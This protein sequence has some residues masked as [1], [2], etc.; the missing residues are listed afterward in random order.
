[1]RLRP[2]LT[3]VLAAAALALTACSSTDTPAPTHTVTV[4]APTPDTT[5]APTPASDDMTQLVV[6][7]S[8]GQQSEDDKDAMCLGIGVYGSEWAAEQMQAGAGDDSVDWNR[9]AE[10][11]EQKCA[12]R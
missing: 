3:T 12:E 9:A 6:D 2:T 7:I 11:V 4:E 5:P 8:W 10:L 1:M